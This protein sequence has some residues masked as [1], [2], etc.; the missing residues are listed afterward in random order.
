MYLYHG[1]AGTMGAAARRAAA[2]AEKPRDV[3]RE[4]AVHVAFP[5]GARGSGPCEDKKLL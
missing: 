5:G 4:L 3:S 2:R 1:T